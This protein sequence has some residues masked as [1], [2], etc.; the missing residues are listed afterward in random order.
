[1]T[2]SSLP[3]LLGF[4]VQQFSELLAAYQ[5]MGATIATAESLTGGL[6]TAA[7]TEA[8]GA[9]TVIRGGVVC[10]A[11]DLKSSMVGVDSTLL[12]TVGPVH[13]EVA[14]QLAV[15]IRLRCHATVG[16]ALTGVAGPD[17]QHGLPPGTVYVALA[18]AT[19][20]RWQSLPPLS[21]NTRQAIRTA[22]VVLALKMLTK[23]VSGTR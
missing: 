10:Y 6:L 3:S 21:D 13:P 2:S 19:E 9:S 4:S 23:W 16:V 5:G 14:E 20:C 17:P 15:G 8:P 7:L 18:D 22:S 1:M 12:D 11:T